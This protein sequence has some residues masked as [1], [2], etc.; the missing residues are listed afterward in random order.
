MATMHM[1]KQFQSNPLRKFRWKIDFGEK[2]KE[3]EH[4]VRTFARPNMDFEQTELN[5]RHEKMWIAG[6]MT[7]GDISMTV[8]DVEE[9]SSFYQ[10]VT[11]VYNINQGAGVTGGSV[12]ADF[13]LMGRDAG[14]GR[15]KR[16]INLI[17]LDGRGNDIENWKL[18]NV[19]PATVN[20]GDL[21]YTSSDTA[22]IEVTLRFDR[23]SLVRV[24][25]TN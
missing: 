18:Q 24:A 5:F 2:G 4:Y 12:S 8:L 17:M 3:V 22:D 11:D 15:Y 10:W 25:S 19:W 7:W 14:P 9:S 13:A 6:K 20:W 1:G 16:D 21:D 23:A